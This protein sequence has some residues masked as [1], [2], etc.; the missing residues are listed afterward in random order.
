M[1]GDRSQ[2]NFRLV[3]I[4]LAAATA[5][6]YWPITQH[7][8]IVFDD[9]DYV[10]G[11]PAVNSG[12]SRANLIWAFNGAHAANWHPLT[13]LSHQLDCTL[14]GLN[15]GRHHL[16]NLLLHV[17]N[18]LLVL[19]F[20]RRTT[21][22]RWRSAVVAGLF[23]WHPLHVE[24]VAWA[25]ERKDTLST[26][27]WLLTLLAYVAYAS[28]DSG[29]LTPATSPRSGRVTHHA[30]RFYFAALF[31]FA[32]GLMSKPMVVTLPFVLLLLDVWPLGR[33]QNR[34]F[35][36]AAFT[37]LLLEKIPFFALT[38]AG[39]ATT[40]L[41][42]AAAMSSLS[43][44]ER[45]GNAMLAYARY[46]VKLFW[47]HDLAIVYAH[48]KETPWLLALTA[49]G[50]LLFWTVPLLL[51]WRRRPWL[52]VGWLWFLGTLVPTI[53]L[54]QVG[55]QSMADRYTYI[56][57]IGFF[58]VLVWGGAEI[59][60]RWPRGKHLAVFLAVAGLLGCAWG[61]AR[62]ISYWRDS[63]TLF[64]HALEVT[65]DNYVAANSL[66]KAYE[67]AGDNARALYLYRA[68]VASEPRFPVSQFN[69]A[70][71][72]LELGD[73]AAGIEHLQTAAQ[74][75]PENPD[76]HFNLG[77]YALRHSNW[78]AAAQ[79]LSNAIALRPGFVPA[80][81]TLAGV[82]LEAGKL[83]EAEAQFRAA[84][85]LEPQNA[86]AQTGLEKLARA[87]AGKP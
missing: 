53:G 30:S 77:V 48:P 51:N 58:V 62:Q 87:A 75:Q 81:N 56:P 78:L 57:S 59:C 15:A 40:Y 19:V 36:L 29:P 68:A 23:A 17:L 8:F 63:I 35:E 72:L 18:T 55:A 47:P 54:V 39:C 3:C 80:H 83:T 71:T 74:L 33:V 26:C 70:M 52:A 2:N 31:F 14:F 60:A 65:P 25:S 12:W 9:I 20:L 6:L 43:L 45:L 66:G 24:S 7:P 67:L 82:L 76:I 34:K 46:V 84:L 21:G 16:V 50:L 13:W 28:A 85:R 27:F 69:L 41:S 42:Q 22:S 73:E 86:A 10:T 49:L 38:V 4:F 32:C 37:P 64:R 44:P 5:A 1:T 79:S 61:T 11:N